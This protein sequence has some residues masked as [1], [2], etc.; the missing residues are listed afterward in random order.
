[1]EDRFGVLYT[2][3]SKIKENQSV[4]IGI[5]IHGEETA[6][7]MSIDRRCSVFTGEILAIEKALGYII[8]NGW[9]KDILL[10]SDNQAAVKDLYNT[11]M[12]YKKSEIACEIK[13]KKFYCIKKYREMFII[14]KLK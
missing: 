13:R 12:S 10:V 6:F 3:T 9:S 2:V 5:V 14:R 4:S 8:E 1:M 7:S 11:T